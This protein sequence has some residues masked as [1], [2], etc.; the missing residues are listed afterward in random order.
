MVYR[1]TIAQHPNPNTLPKN[2]YTHADIQVRLWQS[3]R[4]AHGKLWPARAGG[5]QLRGSAC[6]GSEWR[7]R[8]GSLSVP[9]AEKS[10][11]FC[12]RGSLPSWDAETS[13]S[14]TWVTLML[15][16]RT[17]YPP[18]FLQFDFGKKNQPILRFVQPLQR[19]LGK[20]DQSG[21]WPSCRKVKC[22]KRSVTKTANNRIRIHQN[23][24]PCR[25]RNQSHH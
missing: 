6:R 19:L 1:S 2:K 11:F 14:R 21:I 5:R 20:C 23:A 22:L 4:R 18:D 3:N 13:R 7:P 8:R 15:F 17:S 12:T 10:V 9:R 24:S 16:L 25:H